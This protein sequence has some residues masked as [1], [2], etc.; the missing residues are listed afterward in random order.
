[1][2]TMPAWQKQVFFWWSWQRFGLDA[3]RQCCQSLRKQT[4]S[5]F[6]RAAFSGAA[7]VDEPKPSNTV[8]TTAMGSTFRIG[9]ESFKGPQATVKP[10]QQKTRRGSL[11]PSGARVRRSAELPYEREVVGPYGWARVIRRGR[12]LVGAQRRV[13]VR[14]DGR[15][16][17]L[18]HRPAV[19]GITTGMPL[20]GLAV[21]VFGG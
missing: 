17:D 13:P 15:N 6:L 19:I 2:S 3:M 11:P 18:C 8:S 21:R 16:C 7:P 4:V 10:V 1:M 20:M 12:L 9:R 5:G 14:V